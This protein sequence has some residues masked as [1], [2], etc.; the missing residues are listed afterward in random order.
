MRLIYCTT[1]ALFA[2]TACNNGNPFNANTQPTKKLEM[3]FGKEKTELELYQSKLDSIAN[4][5]IVLPTDTVSLADA[6]VKDYI[7]FD[8]LY[9]QNGSASLDRLILKAREAKE[10]KT[11]GSLNQLTE[12][13]Q[14]IEQ[15]LKG[16]DRYES[17]PEYIKTVKGIPYFIVIKNMSFSAPKMK[18]DSYF[19]GGYALSFIK[20]YDMK[21]MKMVK[22]SL[23]QVE[24]SNEIETRGNFGMGQIDIDRDFWNNYS[25]EQEKALNSIFN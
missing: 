10:G 1:L 12:S 18:G 5:T 4:G 14:G 8:S 17:Y 15:V 11:S 6:S 7:L 20:V 24:S 3:I 21:A 22:L 9:S 13:L 19:D 25:T 23:F 16:E 2:L